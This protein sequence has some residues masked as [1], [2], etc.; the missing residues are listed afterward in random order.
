MMTDTNSP[1]WRSV[2]FYNKAYQRGLLDPDSFTQKE[3]VAR[4]KIYDGVYM[5]TVPGW[6]AGEANSRFNQ[7]PGNEKAFISLPGIG[8]QRE[9]RFSS[10]FRG[11]RFYGASSKTKY[12][13]RVAALLDLVS[14]YEFSR[15]MFNG[16]EGNGDWSMVN[17]KPVPTDAYLATPID[18]AYRVKTGAQVYHHFM[19]YGNGTVDPVTGTPVD[20]WTY[21]PQAIAKKM[22]ASHR[23]FLSYYGETDWVE[24]YRKQTPITDSYNMIA[25]GDPPADLKNYINAFSAYRGM[26]VFKLIAARSDAEFDRLLRE[27]IAG[28]ADYHVDEIFQYFYDQALTQKDQVAKYIQMMRE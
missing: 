17:G 8:A 14:S 18:D 21:S 3:D 28:M 6:M 26:N 27:H 15:I 4:Q 2:R 13:E 25:F 16:L 24:V 9:H 22:T 11:E 23:D 10:M 19:G 5:F 1:Y 20:L 7:V 12:P